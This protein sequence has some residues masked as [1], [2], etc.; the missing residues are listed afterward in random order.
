MIIM[1]IKLPFNPL[2][3]SFLPLFP[4]CSTNETSIIERESVKSTRESFTNNDPLN[5][6]CV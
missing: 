5:M 2:T 1:N 4:R 3:I 6:T